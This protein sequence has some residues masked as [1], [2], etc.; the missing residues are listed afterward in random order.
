MFSVRVLKL[1][2]RFDGIEIT[3]LEKEREGNDK[4]RLG[5]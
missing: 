4:D 5:F 1:R 2:E 3:G